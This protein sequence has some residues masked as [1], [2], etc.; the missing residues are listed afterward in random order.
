MKLFDLHCDTAYRCYTERTPM[1]KNEFHI[2]LERGLRYDPWVQCFAVWMPDEKRGQEAVALFKAVAD[3]FQSELRGAGDKISQY[4]S[5]EDLESGRSLAILTV[6]GGGALGGE[7]ETLD[8]MRDYGV[9]MLTLTWNGRCELGSGAL[10][11]EDIGLSDFGRE[12]VRRMEALSIIP[13]LSHAS[14]KL[15]WDVC[16]ETERPFAVSHSNL[17]ALCDHPRN[18][19]DEQFQEV[20]RRG[21][22][23]GL[24]FCIH[25]LDEKRHGEKDIFFRH[26]DRM[27]SLGGEKTVALGGDF[28]GTDVP[29]YLEGIQSMA[30]LREEM[31]RRG[32]SGEQTDAL[33]FDNA[34]RFFG[35]FDK[36]V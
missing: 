16:H 7:L 14:E 15:F 2:S 10:D 28:D 12:A 34:R 20:V 23:V 6:E 19:T 33:F 30:A 29:A 5:A 13:D 3:F 24:N 4:R 36:P 26:L 8:L 22:L 11:A 18:L 9:K 27:L 1:A 25:F 31:L 17:K 21:G 35:G 32:Y